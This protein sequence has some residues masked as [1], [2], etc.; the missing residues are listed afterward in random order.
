MDQD[1]AEHLRR[2]DLGDAVAGL[3]KEGVYSLERLLQL[4]DDDVDAMVQKGDFPDFPI[5]TGRLVKNKLREIAP[6][7][8]FQTE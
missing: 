4:T 8:V 5:M 7:K 3:E 6:I 1:V 2:H